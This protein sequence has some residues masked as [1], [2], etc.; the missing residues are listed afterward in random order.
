MSS[1]RYG[2]NYIS[3][4]ECSRKILCTRGVQ[5][6]SM[7]NA[8]LDHLVTLARYCVSDKGHHCSKWLNTYCH[9]VIDSQGVRLDHLK[10]DLH[11]V[12]Q[13]IL[14]IHVIT[15]DRF[16][17]DGSRILE[18]YLLNIDYLNTMAPD[19]LSQFKTHLQ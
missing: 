5:L 8:T 17:S 7:D 19:A 2:F 4:P 10:L 16:T 12:P 15:T 6:N 3:V 11:G 9:T 18:G 14:T 1:C 13:V